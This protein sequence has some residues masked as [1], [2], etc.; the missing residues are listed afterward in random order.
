ME[1][2]AAGA[3]SLLLLQGAREAA[4]GDPEGLC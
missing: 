3:I 2:E 1:E 4:G